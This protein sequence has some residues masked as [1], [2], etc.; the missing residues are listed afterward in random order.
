[1]SQKV[2]EEQ[3][4]EAGLDNVLS[5]YPELTKNWKSVSQIRDNMPK[6]R[7]ALNAIAP[8]EH[9]VIYK[10]DIPVLSSENLNILFAH[11]S[12][13]KYEVEGL[14]LPLYAAKAFPNSTIHFTYDK[15]ATSPLVFEASSN[16]E[17]RRNN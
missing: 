2:S 6:K 16:N 12:P 17:T 4:I 1:M 15:H 9:K 10:K 8:Q 3:F 5:R 7:N 11:F 14:G 13:F